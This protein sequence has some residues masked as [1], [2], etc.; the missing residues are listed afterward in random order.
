MQRKGGGGHGGDESSG[1]NG[2]DGRSEHGGGN[3]PM[4]MQ[5]KGEVD[6]EEIALMEGTVAMQ[7]DGRVLIGGGKI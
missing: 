4:V 2:G 5:R 6:M 7:M 3:G 1:S